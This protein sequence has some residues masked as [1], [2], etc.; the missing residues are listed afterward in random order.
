MSDTQATELWKRFEN[1][2]S[3]QK[4]MGFSNLFPTCVDFKE[5][6][7]WPA[8]T[9]RTKHLPRP[10]FNICEFYIRTKASNILNQ[11]IKMLYSP[12]QKDDSRADEGAK[13]YSDY[14]ETLWKEMQHDL[15][16]EEFID[17]AAT[18]GTGILHYYWDNDVVG[19]VRQPIKG[20]LRG[21]ILDPMTVFFGNP[22][23]KRVQKQPLILIAQRCTVAAVRELAKAEKLPQEQI[24][25]ISGDDEYADNYQAARQEMQD[26]KKCTL[27]ICYYRKNGNVY[28]D[29]GTRGVMITSGRSLTPQLPQEESAPEV[30]AAEP[31]G[32]ETVEK[33]QPT[34]TLYP[35]V[36][37]NWRSRKRCA[38]GIGEVEDIIPAQKAINWLHAMNQL[39]VQ[40]MAWPK[41]K[42]KE[43]ALRQPITNEPGEIIIDYSP[44]GDGISYMDPPTF[45]NFVVSLID[46]ITEMSRMV[47]GVSEVASGEPFTATMA[48]SAIIALQNQAK[49]PIEKI[50][51][52]FYR[53]CEEIGRIWEQFFKT[54]YSLPRPMRAKDETGGEVFDQFTGTDYADIDFALDV[55]VGAGSEYSE[56]LAQATLDKLFDGGNIDLDTYIE[57]APKNVM[58]FKETLKRL[59]EQAVL[60]AM[61]AGTVPVEQQVA[62]PVQSAAP[63]GRAP[64]GIPLPQIPQTGGVML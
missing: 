14:A 30:E 37:M 42:T 4:A 58:P 33:I 19:G 45:S 49:Q 56:S 28:F 10:V 32:F 59:R 54:Y 20:G 57:L 52:R 15:L 25:L 8:P 5:G 12:V 62:E 60:K 23:D 29:R 27:L 41:I 53:C 2:M 50:Q 18:V 39:A 21:E 63:S 35:I 1:G 43:G 55:D 51:R 24:E 61:Q 9:K 36:I 46:K 3:Y 47:S 26:D 64:L 7:Q 13:K 34:I 40:D 48:A 38:F 6:R 44:S 31:D 22:Q 11:N 16:N 17:D